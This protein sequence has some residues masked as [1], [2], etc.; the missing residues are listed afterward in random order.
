MIDAKSFD[1]AMGTLN[2]FPWFQEPLAGEAFYKGLDMSR[3]DGSLNHVLT[4]REA[5]IFRNI[6]YS[7]YHLG[8]FRGI[9]TERAR[10]RR[11]I[12]REDYTLTARRE[13][14]P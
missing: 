14:R 8:K 5:Q 10:R 7:F 12:T 1:K 9:Q 3:V 13:Y 11:E 2:P 6:A 4:K